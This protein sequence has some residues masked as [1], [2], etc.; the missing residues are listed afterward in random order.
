MR[1]IGTLS[2]SIVLVAICAYIL[3]R[4]SLVIAVGL[5]RSRRVR[6]AKGDGLSC[7]E[8]ISY[9][10]AWA[11]TS[12]SDVVFCGANVDPTVVAHCPSPLRYLSLASLFSILGIVVY[13]NY[14]RGLWGTRRCHLIPNCSHFAIGSLRRYPFLQALN[15]IKNRINSCDGVRAGLCLEK[16]DVCHDYGN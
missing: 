6:R 4:V 1:D 10:W 15:I 3:L 14:L 7:V 5:I 2:A 16:K 13:Q 8:K 9:A 11:E 12:E